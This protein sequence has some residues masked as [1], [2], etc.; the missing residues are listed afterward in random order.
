MKKVIYILLLFTVNNVFSQKPVISSADNLVN[1]L[2]GDFNYSIPIVS[3][4]GPNGEN[5]SVTLNYSAG[6]KVHQPASWVGLGWSLNPGEI[7]RSANGYPDDWNGIDISSTKKKGSSAIQNKTKKVYGPLYFK[8]IE[9]PKSTDQYN[10]DIGFANIKPSG[11]AEFPNYDNFN[12]S[13]PGLN[14]QMRAHLFDN[15]FFMRDPYWISGAGTFS[16][17]LP[18]KQTEPFEQG[19]VFRFIDDLDGSLEYN[20]DDSLVYSVSNQ[21]GE[22][23]EDV[24]YKAAES[25]HGARYVEM[26]TNKDISDG[27]ANE[28]GFMECYVNG[29]VLDRSSFNP[30]EIGA[31][32][33]TNTDGTVYHYSLP[34]YSS[35][36]NKQFSIDKQTGDVTDSF[37][38][39]V[40]QPSYVISW[41]LTAITGPYFKDIN[42]NNIVDVSDQ[43][44]WV[45]Y[46]YGL[47]TEEFEWV[48][49]R[50]GYSQNNTRG[51]TIDDFINVR[52]EH[53]ASVTNGVS[54]DYYLNSIQTVSHTACFLKGIR[55]DEH[56]T[57][58]K[59]SLYLKKVLLVRNEDVNSVL[60][61][62]MGLQNISFDLTECNSDIWHEGMYNPNFKDKVLNATEFT[63]DYSLAPSYFTNISNNIVSQAIN[64]N[65]TQLFE[66]IN[67]FNGLGGKLSLKSLKQFSN[68]YSSL[69]PQYTF[70][71]QYNPSFDADKVDYWGYYKSDYVLGS[72]RY[73]SNKSKDDIKAWSLSKINSPTGAELSIFYESDDFVKERDGNRLRNPLLIFQTYTP[74]ISS[75]NKVT[76]DL[77]FQD[78]ALLFGSTFIESKCQ[79]YMEDKIYSYSYETKSPIYDGS[80]SYE[81]NL[82]DFGLI[83][84][85]A[86]KK[87]GG[88]RVNNIQLKESSSDDVYKV[89]YAYEGGISDMEVDGIT[90]SNQNGYMRAFLPDNMSALLRNDVLYKKVSRSYKNLDGYVKIKEVFDFNVSANLQFGLKA[91]FSFDPGCAEFIPNHLRTIPFG[92]M[93][94]WV[95]PPHTNIGTHDDFGIFHPINEYD[96]NSLPSLVLAILM[97]TEDGNQTLSYDD[98]YTLE[99]LIF[100]NGIECP[101]GSNHTCH[102]VEGNLNHPIINQFSPLSF[103]AENNM[104]DKTLMYGKLL[105]KT[106]L[107]EN[108]LF[109]SQ[110]KYNYDQTYQKTRE[111]FSKDIQQARFNDPFIYTKTTFKNSYFRPV[112]KSITKISKKGVEHI[113]FSDRDIHT[114]EPKK[115]TNSLTLKTTTS[116]K[117]YELSGFEQLGSKKDDISNKNILTTSAQEH[118]YFGSEEV[119]V[120]ANESKWHTSHPFISHNGNYAIKKSKSMLLPQY[121]KVYNGKAQDQWDELSRITLRDDY[122][123]SLEE[124]DLLIDR[125]SSKKFG[126][127]DNYQTYWATNS[128]YLSSTHSSFE[129]VRPIERNPTKK[130]QTK[131]GGIATSSVPLQMLFEGDVKGSENRFA[132][133]N[134]LKAHTGSHMLRISEDLNIYTIPRLSEEIKGKEVQIGFENGRTYWVGIWLHQNSHASAKMRVDFSGANSQLISKTD[135]NNIQ[136]GDWILLRTKIKVPKNYNPNLGDEIN[137]ILETEDLAYFD[138]FMIHPIDADVSAKVY[139]PQTG[140]VLCQLNGEGFYTRM[141]YDGLGRQTAIFQETL[142]GVKKLKSFT[143]HVT[144]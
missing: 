50:Y 97:K 117:V 42:N 135:P 62:S 71:Y 89:E 10:M 12:V 52:F 53:Q 100:E 35:Y 41:K 75:D 82:K 31:F 86:T 96:E 27:I 43:G 28:S 17:R 16:Y 98:D 103:K 140:R 74:E 139:D 95:N 44:Y 79:L 125:F 45:T 124:Y 126:Y 15:G 57:A 110:T 40:N 127:K 72:S 5:V 99:D 38:E 91:H 9:N 128:N 60:S 48:N 26:F 132:A 108:D 24:V 58:N 131:G 144:E 51:T 66:K 141:E 137:V 68:K 49:P 13:G 8:D 134:Q 67:S 102:K 11:M 94:S 101:Y 7:S 29:V 20:T 104:S 30:H 4:P 77:S 113:S 138:D 39:I 55:N 25:V 64:S 36:N 63:H 121:N 123:N 56:S 143:Y 84:Q 69:T 70:D 136:V 21:D 133:T 90:I 19:V 47:W 142:N 59:P 88:L 92:T 6:I 22:Y 111:T 18:I 87:G 115:I 129:S 34:V 32:K 80:Y 3:V 81:T 37:L 2:T 46:N 85:K 116:K 83:Y 93:R 119:I 105:S 33:I 122:L 112:L 73:V 107:G 106:V 118:S 23:I 65:G 114:S 109:I 76:Y 120:S 54:E 1:P 130:Y 78:Q 14:G 61:G